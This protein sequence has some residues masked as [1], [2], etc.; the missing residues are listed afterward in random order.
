MIF[1]WV[2]FITC[3]VVAFYVWTDACFFGIPE[4]IAAVLPGPLPMLEIFWL[5][6]IPVAL[7]AR[8]DG[9]RLEALISSQEIK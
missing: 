1:T 8:R 2:S 6:M 4:Y 9:R 5:H 3:S 7:I